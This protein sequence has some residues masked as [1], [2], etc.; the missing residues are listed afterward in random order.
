MKKFI[1]KFLVILM[2]STVAIGAE[3]LHVSEV[4]ALEASSSNASVTVNLVIDASKE[5]SDKTVSA[6]ITLSN[7]SNVDTTNLALT[8]NVDFDTNL[9][10]LDTGN[11]S[12]AN[13]YTATYNNGKIVIDGSSA[14]TNG[15]NIATL[16]FNVKAVTA[17]T[18][19]AIKLSSIEVV[20]NS[21][22][23]VT[24]TATEVSQN[25]AL[26]K[27][28]ETKPSE[29][30]NETDDGKLH[31][32]EIVTPTNETDNKAIN[33][34]VPETTEEKVQK[35]EPVKDPTTSDKAIPQTGEVPTAV[36]V[37]GII[38]LIAIG[39]ATFIRYKKFYD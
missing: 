38:A 20:D 21:E 23:N 35:I 10:S 22:K 29:N 34:P 3:A 39:V 26:H 13:G 18:S 4:N 15:I 1:K 17:D 14:E 30:T 19:T 36:K 11:V 12:G 37:A 28:A 6:N 32:N 27:N 16:K 33:N 5:T 25:V 24:V 2:I 31:R 8:A 7:F 9:L